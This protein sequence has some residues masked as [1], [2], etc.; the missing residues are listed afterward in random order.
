MAL[1]CWLFG[2]NWGPWF[3]RE[4][5]DFE[6]PPFDSEPV[7]LASATCT[8]CGQWAASWT[9]DPRQDGDD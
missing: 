8:R 7:D 4:V 6:E 2:H 3:D 5:A 9:T 1:R